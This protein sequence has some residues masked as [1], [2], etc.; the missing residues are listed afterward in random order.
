MR[1]SLAAA[2]ALCLFVVSA[3]CSET[4]TSRRTDGQ[5]VEARLI[6]SDQRHVYVRPGYAATET[7][8]PRAE[9]VDIDHPG[10]VHLTVGSIL[11]GMGMI[12]GVI[13]GLVAGMSN[14]PIDQAAS[15]AMLMSGAIWI[16]AGAPLIYWGYT[17]WFGSRRALEPENAPEQT[18]ERLR[19]VRSW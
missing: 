3:G 18:D 10:N 19:I 4:A 14:D 8:I 17:R 1:R 7:P 12:G 2:A 9:I 15:E 5:V 16:A 13:P 6:R 11:A